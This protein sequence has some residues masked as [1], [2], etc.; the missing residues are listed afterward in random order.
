MSFSDDE[1][2]V[3][4]ENMQEGNQLRQT[5][6]G[7]RWVQ[8][9][10]QLRHGG[11]EA[12]RQLAMTELSLLDAFHRFDGKPV[13]EQACQERWVCRVARPE[14]GANDR[15]LERKQKVGTSDANPKTQLSVN[16]HRIGISASGTAFDEDDATD[17]R[18]C[19]AYQKARCCNFLRITHTFI[20][21]TSFSAEGL[22]CWAR[23]HNAAD[24]DRHTTEH[25]RNDPER[26]LGAIASR[27]CIDCGFARW[28]F[29]EVRSRQLILRGNL[30]FWRRF[31]HRLCA[32][33]PDDYAR[34]MR[35]VDLGETV[36]PSWA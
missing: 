36:P 35:H 18:N 12:S 31:G 15:S 13:T 27:W 6:A 25:G 30:N 14:H 32:C 8:K 7:V 33:T 5:L 20:G 23:D 34:V 22:Q 29:R 9:A 3:A 26:K 11:A 10:I 24:V 17:E 16:G 28:R 4:V 1:I 2:D 21:V 19:T